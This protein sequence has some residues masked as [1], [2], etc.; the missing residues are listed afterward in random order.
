M[1]RRIGNFRISTIETDG[2]ESLLLESLDRSWRVLW[3][4]DAPM[5]GNMMF[6]LQMA[7]EEEVIAAYLERLVVSFFAH[8]NHVHD[9]SV[10]CAGG[11]K[12]EQGDVEYLPFLTQYFKMCEAA[13]QRDVALEGEIDAKS[14][15][16][17][18]N[19]VAEMTEIASELEKV[20]KEEAE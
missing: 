16:A 12:N 8:T 20:E 14:D 4:E 9:W 2:M 7:A 6:V 11:V 5:Y 19:E 17:A 18:L 3:R 10:M 13:V 1:E 15:E